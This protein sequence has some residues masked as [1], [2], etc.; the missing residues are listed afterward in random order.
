KHFPDLPLIEGTEVINPKVSP[1]DQKQLTTDYTKRAVEFIYKNK[2]KPFLLYVAH[3]MPHVPLFVSEKFQGRSPQGIY[4]DV[5]MEID[6]SV[7]QI[8]EALEKN[9]LREKTLVIYTSDNGPWLSYGDHAGS[10]YPLREGKGTAWD[11]GVRVPC[12]MSWPGQVPAAR[13][14]REPAMTIDLV[15][16]VAEL[17]GGELPEHGVDGKSILPLI[18]GEEGAKSPQEAYYFYW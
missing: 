14:T 16:T 18:R 9:G 15:P 10:A 2:E 17:I 6:W 1:D 7:G 13:T 3:A 11:G 4:G 8:V 12:I 5:I